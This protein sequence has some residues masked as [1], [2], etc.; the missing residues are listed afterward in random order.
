MRL[1]CLQCRNLE[2]KEAIL[3]ALKKEVSSLAIYKSTCRVS[4]N[5]III[6]SVLY[7]AEVLL[8][9]SMTYS[10]FEY[11]KENAEDLVTVIPTESQPQEQVRW[12]YM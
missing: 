7:Q 5:C 11:A 4:C 2:S 10:L 1:Y 3:T 12:L 9:S 8:G 6:T